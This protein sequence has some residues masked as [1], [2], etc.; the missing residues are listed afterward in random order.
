MQLE[1]AS[2]DLEKTCTDQRAMQKKLGAQIA[3]TLKLRIAEM[4]R[5]VEMGDLLLGTGRWEELKGDRAGEWSARLSANWRLVVQP[6]DRDVV[7]V[8]V[9]EIVDYHKT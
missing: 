2:R 5:A 3:K 8:L 9:L 6:V 7:T 1:Y 4:R